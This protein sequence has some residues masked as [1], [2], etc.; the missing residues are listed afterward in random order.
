MGIV[1]VIMTIVF[2]IGGLLKSDWLYSVIVIALTVA[3]LL[4]VYYTWKKAT[5]DQKIAKAKVVSKI[6]IGVSMVLT[7]IGFVML[8]WC[9]CLEPTSH[10]DTFTKCGL[11]GGDGYSFGKICSLC[12]GRGGITRSDPRYS[13]GM[14]TWIGA[15]ITSSSTVI[16]EGTRSIMKK[17]NSKK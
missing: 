7:V 14:Y 17:H 3:T 16:N 10:V 4:L 6:V 5:N 11:C 9:F 15:L 12:H 1:G 13:T 2:A 8:V